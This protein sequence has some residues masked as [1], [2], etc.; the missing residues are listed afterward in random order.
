[1]TGEPAK[2]CRKAASEERGDGEIAVFLARSF[3][4]ER[5]S[6]AMG[7]KRP[8]WKSVVPCVVLTC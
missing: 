2:A 4:I 7:V 8:S 1:M 6:P 3:F 5:E